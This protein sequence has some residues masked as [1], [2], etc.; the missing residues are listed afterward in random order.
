MPLF[1]CH[2]KPAR[3]EGRRAH[4]G[5]MGAARQTPSSALPA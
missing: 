2:E 1:R 4:L 5:T 3:I